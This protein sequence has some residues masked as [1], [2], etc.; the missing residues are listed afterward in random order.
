MGQP[1]W[2]A[3]PA[4]RTRVLATDLAAANSVERVSKWQDLD[5]DSSIAALCRRRQETAKHRPVLP[6]VPLYF[7]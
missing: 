5:P 2:I 6:P 1:N 7:Q 4:V 3:E